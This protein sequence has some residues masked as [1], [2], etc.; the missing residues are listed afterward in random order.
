MNDRI[1]GTFHS[2]QWGTVTAEAFKYANGATAIQLYTAEGEPLARLSVNT[3]FSA[4]LDP[5]FFYAKDW[6][7]NQE[8]AADALASGLFEMVD[9]MPSI[10][11]GYE[12][13]DVWRIV[14]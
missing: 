7:E 11:C 9:Y 3:E 8:I 2:A 12:M 14:G 1:I 5:A 13:A 4:H 10:I 6:S